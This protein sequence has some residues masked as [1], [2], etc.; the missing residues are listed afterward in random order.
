MSDELEELVNITGGPLKP[1]E[2]ILVKAE[3]N[4]G[5]D[6]WIQ[7]HAAK[8]RGQGRD[9]EIVLTIG[10]VRLSTAKRLV[11]GWS[12]TK[13]LTNPITGEKS[14]VQVPFSTEAIEKLPGKV[15]R[16]LL[17]KIDEL[18]PDDE[19]ESDDDFLP[20]VIDSS[21]DNLN[22]ERVLRRKH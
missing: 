10:D 19:E 16:Y 20:A 12:L 9:A 4:A 17:K 6:A 7:N 5:D 3:M 2:Y 21:E 22:A 1:H 14:T 13:D 8:S 15:Y 11:K 18:N